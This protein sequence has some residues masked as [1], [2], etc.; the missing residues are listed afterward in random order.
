M[1]NQIS[2]ALRALL[3]KTTLKGFSSLKEQTGCECLWRAGNF[4]QHFCFS[5][6]DFLVG[7]V[8]LK[9]YFNYFKLCMCVFVWVCAYEG[10][11]AESGARRIYLKQDLQVS[12]HLAIS[13][14][15][16]LSLSEV[17][18][19]RFDSFLRVS[20]GPQ[21]GNNI[22]W[23]HIHFLTINWENRSWNQHRE[24]VPTSD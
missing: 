21:Y 23:F 17:Y 22:H 8:V 12:V 13:S 15:W 11:D 10:R 14:A 1:Y 2:A 24:K 19:S 16:V 7:L 4:S 3:T 9:I 20:N 5:F 6:R 18:L